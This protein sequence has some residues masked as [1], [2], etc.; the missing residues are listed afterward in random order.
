MMKMPS[1]VVGMGIVFL[2]GAGGRA[3]CVPA[4]GKTLLV[5]GQD[6]GAIAGYAGAFPLPQGLA[7]YTSLPNL[8]GLRARVDYGSGVEDAAD[9]IE[10]YPGLALQVGLY[11][12]GELENVTAG[13]HDIPLRMLA[14]WIAAARVPVYLRIGYEF[15]NPSNEYEPRAYQQTYRYIVRAIRG[16]GVP[17]VAFVWHSW[18]FVPSGERPV[19]D[20]Y[21][22]DDAVDWVGVSLFQQIYVRAFLHADAIASFAHGRGKPLAVCESTPIGGIATPASA[23]IVHGPAPEIPGGL[24]VD[25]W[26][27]WFEPLLLWIQTR[28]AKM[29]SYINCDWD[30]Q[31]MWTGQGWG[32][33]RLEA[34]EVIASLWRAHVVEEDRFTVEAGDC[35]AGTSLEAAPATAL[36]DIASKGAQNLGGPGLGPMSRGERAVLLALALTGF[37]GLVAATAGPALTRAVHRLLDRCARAPVGTRARL[38]ADGGRPAR[39]ELPMTGWP[40]AEGDVPGDAQAEYAAPSPEQLR[41][42]Q[43]SFASADSAHKGGL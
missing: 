8:D 12:V 17:N 43:G 25:S 30:S 32:D 31:P 16:R 38:L 41:E 23:T 24:V 7:V 13:V 21:P 15:D 22:G 14:D 34:D 42:S 4:D 33:T 29:L 27:E 18:G 3:P 19:E 26:S 39:V 20:W 1:A 9:L 5:V 11:L 2:A 6:S 10:D 37:V 28:N 36:T 40:R 35:E